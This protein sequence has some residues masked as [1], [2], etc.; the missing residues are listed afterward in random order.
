M[1][2]KPYPVTPDGRYFLVKDRLWRR[3]QFVEPIYDVAASRRES[4]SYKL[5]IKWIYYE[6]ACEGE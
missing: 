1:T 4:L 2:R 6:F 3:I 5:G